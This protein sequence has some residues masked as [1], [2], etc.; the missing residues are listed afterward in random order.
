MKKLRSVIRHIL[1]PGRRD[2]ELTQELQFHLDMQIQEYRSQGLSDTESRRRAMLDL[3]GLEQT[4]E[5]CGEASVSHF[6]DILKQDIHYGIRSLLREPIFLLIVLL[7]MSLAIAATTA[8][9]SAVYA[10]LFKPLPYDRP[11]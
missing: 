4:R 7:V 6:V 10:V 8:V 2:A 11:E 9:F 1:H 3:G 5:S